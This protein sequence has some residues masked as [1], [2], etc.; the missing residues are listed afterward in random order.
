MANLGTKSL[1]A[2]M[3][4]RYKWEPQRTNHFEVTISKFDAATTEVISLAVSTF[5]L[6][7]I[8]NDPIE[9]PHG[10]SRIKFAGQASFGGSESLE[11]IDYVG[12]DIE[13]I[14]LGWKNQVY[15]PATDTMG[16]AAEYKRDIF[17][18]EFSPD[19][20]QLSK[21]QLE[22]A[23]PSGVAF[24]D[25]LSMDGSEVKKITMTIAYDKGYRVESTR[26]QAG[27]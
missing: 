16:L 1:M 10:N 8:T 17:V 27:V 21:W 5:S 2:D 18:T 12:V 20:K 22:G 6:P 25:T 23:W 26:S 3:S 7:N 11:V 24:G 15:N 19:G 4:V 13:G 14:I 9:V